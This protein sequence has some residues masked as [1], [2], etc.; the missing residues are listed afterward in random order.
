MYVCVYIYIYVLLVCISIII[1]RIIVVITSA[2]NTSST[3]RALLVPLINRIYTGD[4]TRIIR[5]ST[6][7]QTRVNGGFCSS[8]CSNRI[9][10][11]RVSGKTFYEV[12]SGFDGLQEPVVLRVTSLAGDSHAG[13]AL[14]YYYY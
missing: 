7:G 12:P 13:E 3:N 5:G 11:V 8:I 10:I 6:A 9:W 4:E 1:S 2:A 14:D